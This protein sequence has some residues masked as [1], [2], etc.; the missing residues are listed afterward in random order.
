MYQHVPASL[1]HFFVNLD[2]D[3]RKCQSV[4]VSMKHRVSTDVNS[5]D[6]LLTFGTCYF[7]NIF[8]FYCVRTRGSGLKYPVPCN[9]NKLLSP[10]PLMAMRLSDPAKLTMWSSYWRISCTAIVDTTN[11]IHCYSPVTRRLGTTPSIYVRLND[12]NVDSLIVV[13][14]RCVSI[15]LL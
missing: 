12:P 1:P 10:I 13:I 14:V 7:Y 15:Q 5:I 2:D 6:C 8:K 9:D 3:S 11:G 4:S